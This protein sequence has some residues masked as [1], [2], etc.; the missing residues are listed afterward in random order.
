[1]YEEIFKAT[2]DKVPVLGI[3]KARDLIDLA[4]ITGS[5]ARGEHDDYSDVDLF[6]VIPLAIQKQ[7]KLLPEY[8]EQITIDSSTYKVEVSFVTTRK[9]KLGQESKSHIFWWR[10]AICVYAREP[11]FRSMLDKAANYSSAQ[12]ADTL[13]TL[14]FQFKLGLYDF[15]KAMKR[16]KDDTICQDLVYYDCIRTF[17]E[18]MLVSS[19]TIRRFTNFTAKVAEQYPEHYAYIRE[20]KSDSA[21]RY[22]ALKHLSSVIDETLIRYGFSTEEVTDWG[23]HNLTKLTF[24][25]Y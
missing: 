9:L 19:D 7:Y 22:H 13:W 8:T 25:R 3:L 2:C 21:S 6:I 12:K 10:N 18:L 23:A 1:M 5:F 14:H 15:E 17:L 16:R 24:Q 4:A 20:I 11:K